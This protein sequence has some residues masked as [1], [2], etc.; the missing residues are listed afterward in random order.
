M[1]ENDTDRDYAGAV[2]Q[3]QADMARHQRDIAGVPVTAE[4]NQQ[5][6]VDIVQRLERQHADEA[7]QPKLSP[8]PAPTQPAHQVERREINGQIYTLDKS[9]TDTQPYRTAT[10]FEHDVVR[11]AMP[12]IQHLM[13]L[14]ESATGGGPS[15][16]QRT[17]AA[18][19]FKVK[20]HEARQSCLFDLADEYE[21]RFQL[22]LYELLEASNKDFGDWRKDTPQ[23]LILT[24][25]A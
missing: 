14:K 6:A 12:R 3:L 8:P 7:R 13:T 16:A 2:E 1:A 24:A 18:M 20:Q 9:T 19:F 17:M 10:Q 25:K 22:D 11:H 21:R 5:L 23:K 15:W 4:S